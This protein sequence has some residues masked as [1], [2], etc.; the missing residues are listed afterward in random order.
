MGVCAPQFYALE[1]S[2]GAILDDCSN[3]GV[4]PLS[5]PNFLAFNNG[6]IHQTGVPK[7]P[8]IIAFPG[9]VSTVTLSVSGG[10]NAGVPMAIVA[11]GP[12]GVQDVQ[13][14]MTTSGWTSHSVSGTI[15]LI[16]LVG[17]PPW[18]VVDNID[19]Q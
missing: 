3:F 12:G 7:L 2:G 14:L 11:I 5:A 1:T 10:G 4:S 13:I 17:N 18:L 15:N 8:Q 9:G 6:S 19:A 16:A